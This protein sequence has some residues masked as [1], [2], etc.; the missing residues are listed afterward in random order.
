M[1]SDRGFF[2]SYFP[3]MHEP[4]LQRCL[5]LAQQGRGKTG[6]NPMVGAVL[7]RN[8]KIIAEG[9]HEAYGK[10]HAELQLMEKFD[11][12]ISSKD[13]LYVNLEPC[14]HELKKTPPCAQMLV[15]KGLKNIVIG[16]KDPNPEVSGKGIELLRNNGVNVELCPGMMA[17][18]L[19]LNRGFVSLMTKGRP[20]VT[21]KQARTAEGETT[22]PDGSTLK[23]TD[24]AQD[25]WS[26]RMLRARHDAIL[27]GVGTVLK[28][29]PALTIRSLENPPNL[30]RI[31]LDPDFKMSPD[32]RVAC[33][34]TIV[35]TS[36]REK[37]QILESKGVR[38]LEVPV[39]GGAFDWSEFWQTLAVPEGEYHGISS[40]LV[41][42]GKR[43]WDIFT[44]A[45]MV[46]EEVVLR[47]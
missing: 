33:D 19:R 31:I 2:V 36:R 18:C 16:M 20:W 21:I 12:K 34:G 10:H 4:F 32:A 17:D 47:G 43:T 25:E 40:I 7:V 39:S 8:K 23:I 44:K 14:C 1:T 38:I 22:K 29:N 45:K 6:T 35:V 30:Y 5:E 42:A 9:F 41:E 13:T 37:A 27:V 3:S 24:A 15:K 11:Q 26:H 28:D 46:D